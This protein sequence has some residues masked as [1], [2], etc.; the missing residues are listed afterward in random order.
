MLF[1]KANDERYGLDFYPDNSVYCKG[2]R[3]YVSRPLGKLLMVP[4]VPTGGIREDD[5]ERF[6]NAFPR[7]IQKLFA[8]GCDAQR[9]LAAYRVFDHS[10]AYIWG[11]AFLA[12]FFPDAVKGGYYQQINMS[13]IDSPAYWAWLNGTTRDSDIENTLKEMWSLAVESSVGFID[14]QDEDT[15]DGIFRRTYYNGEAVNQ[16]AVDS[17]F[18]TA[19][20]LIRELNQ[21]EEVSENGK[22]FRGAPFETFCNRLKDLGTIKK[23]VYAALQYLR[24]AGVAGLFVDVSDNQ[25]KKRIIAQHLAP[26]E[27]SCHTLYNTEPSYAY[28]LQCLIDKSKYDSESG[29]DNPYIRIPQGE[30]KNDCLVNCKSL[31]AEIQKHFEDRANSD[32]RSVYLTN[33]L[34]E[35][36]DSVYQALNEEWD[37][38]RQPIYC[39]ARR[40]ER[41]DLSSGFFSECIERYGLW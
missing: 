20:S 29:A 25:D 10:V 27:Q 32:N 21:S 34:L 37:E 12:R 3:F 35:F 24:E 26:G 28:F 33:H 31:R 14:S 18:F 5:G 13:G 9:W 1:P 30:G 41:R 40:P 39:A 19:G 8:A 6:V 16:R 15:F 22:E 2:M 38:D 11:K 23:R 4:F 36:I 17:V 7:E